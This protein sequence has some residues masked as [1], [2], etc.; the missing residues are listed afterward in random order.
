[1]EALET[2]TWGWGNEVEEAAVTIGGE[3]VGAE[4]ARTPSPPPQAST[5]LNDRASANRPKSLLCDF[6]FLKE[7]VRAKLHVI[8]SMSPLHHLPKLKLPWGAGRVNI[9][10]PGEGEPPISWVHSPPAS[11]L[12]FWENVEVMSSHQQ[13]CMVML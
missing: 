4:A 13:H 11:Q 3:V 5:S 12:A 9:P 1:M 10:P 2:R 6:L 7:I 8:F